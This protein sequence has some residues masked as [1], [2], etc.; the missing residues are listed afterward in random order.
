MVKS[1]YKKMFLDSSTCK[2]LFWKKKI[3][4]FGTGVDA[5]RARKELTDTTE[6]LAYIDNNRHGENRMF[7]GK[8]IIPL[9]HCLEIR[10]A[11]EVILVA[12][13]KY[14]LE[15]C[16][17]LRAQGLVEGND[18]FVWDEEHTFLGDETTEKYIEFLSRIWERSDKNERKGIVLAPF[19]NRH[20]P[21]SIRCA[22]CA[23]Y[24]ADKLHARIY[25]YF[26]SGTNIS[27]ATDVC[28]RIYRAIN[29]E[30]LIDSTLSEVQQ[31]EVNKICASLW[32]QVSTWEDWNNIAIYGI[33]FGTTMIRHLLRSYIPSF[34]IKD[35]RMYS[36]FKQE[37]QTIVFWY[38]Y[39]F[40][41]DIK[42]VLLGNAVNWEGY[43]RDIA[44]KKGIPVYVIYSSHMAKATLGYYQG[45]PYQYFKG[46]WEQLTPE[47]QRYGI[48]WAKEHVEKRLRGG[49]EEVPIWDR[50][51]FAF[52]ESKTNTRVLEKNEK[53]KIMICPH[54]FE[55]ECMYCGE[56]IFDN[57]YFAWLCHLGELSNKTSN[58]D[59]YL[60]MHPSSSKRDFVIIDMILEKY[61]NIK[62]IPNGVSPLQLKEEGVKYALTVYGTIGHEY[63]V[64][65]IQV[66]NAGLNLHSTFDFTWNPTTKEEYDNLIFNLDK[67]EKKED[68]E[69][70]YQFY[71]LNYL[72]YDWDY[73]PW[74]KIFFEN[75]IL[76]MDY[77]ELKAEGKTTGTW[78][79]EEYMK[80]WTQERHE[81]ILAQMEEIFQKLD[82]WRP[83]ILYK[84][85]WRNND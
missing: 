7:Y 3:F 43:I 45:A 75:P 19:S 53:I 71:S 9:E 30:T 21:R 10:N 13:Y 8:R 61:P 2:K 77:M 56:Q 63:P 48:N 55:E 32:S 66:I 83:D 74:R 59:W 70:L 27:N 12:T 42:V 29:V 52:S 80:E 50:N 17:Q 40:S 72:F 28:K 79:Y 51:N 84:R 73:I 78:M 64:I 41:H 49:T 62:K 1:K 82:E 58:Y 60:K 68:M 18:F 35:D 4:I 57:N 85:D 39:I 47:E 20:E 25:A 67:L 5:D 24:F 14:G 33:Q 65:G 31:E 11:E 16:D 23:N 26:Q 44:I 81:R 38:H 36:F 76:S 54:I 6:I 37:I 46:M 22:Y 15:I 34:D 69:G